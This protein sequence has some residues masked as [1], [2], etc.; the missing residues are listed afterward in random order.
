NTGEYRRVGRNAKTDPMNGQQ[1]ACDPADAITGWQRFKDNVPIYCLGRVADGYQPPEREQLGD[2]PEDGKK[3]PWQRIDLLPFWD[4]ES[5]EVLLFNAGNRGS[6]SAVANL[7]GA[8]ADNAAAHPEE[9]GK[10]PLIELATDSYKSQHGK[11]I[12]VPTFEILK[13]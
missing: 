7:I 12:Y 3:D 5:R 9:S 2:L 10:V 4:V 13:W 6:R 1:L 11:Q 8:Y